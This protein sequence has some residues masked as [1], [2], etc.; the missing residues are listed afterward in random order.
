MFWS[1][2]SG[3]ATQLRGDVTSKAS[4][5]AL[6]KLGFCV[7]MLGNHFQAAPQSYALT[8]PAHR[9]THSAIKFAARRVI[10]LQ[11]CRKLTAQARGAAGPHRLLKRA[12]SACASACTRQKAT[13]KSAARISSSNSVCF[14]TSMGPS[15]IPASSISVQ[16]YTSR[17]AP[18]RC[19]A[20]PPRRR[21]VMRSPVCAR[22][23]RAGPGCQ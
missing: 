18:C 21:E 3:Y 16:W 15:G 8:S 5:N 9:E 22:V 1:V 2:A 23:T 6:N 17:S 12:A 4:Q 11:T 13:W 20:P 7:N 19:R 14:A 10:S